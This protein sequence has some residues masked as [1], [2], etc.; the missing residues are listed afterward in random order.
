MLDRPRSWPRPMPDAQALG[1]ELRAMSCELRL[2]RSTAGVAMM[3]TS[4]DL[5]DAGRG[6][7]LRAVVLRGGFCAVAS[8][9]G[10]ATHRHA[11]RSAAC[12]TLCYAVHGSLTY[13]G[14]ART[15]CCAA[16]SRDARGSLAAT[17]GLACGSS[18]AAAVP[19]ARSD[20]ARSGRHLGL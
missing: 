16:A 14:T 11:R 17:A 20:S 18:L 10:L 1:A 6:D 4:R 9:A 3:P 5:A 19:A 2:G 8:E 15:A 12:W 13:L 7:L